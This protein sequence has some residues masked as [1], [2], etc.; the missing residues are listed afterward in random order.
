M[1]FFIVS[2]LLFT[3]YPTQAN[4]ISSAFKLI[5]Q[6]SNPLNQEFLKAVE[7]RDI[8]KAQKLLAEGA[9][10][11]ST[12]KEGYNAL[13][14]AFEKEDSKMAQILLKKNI[15][16]QAKNDKGD[17]AL[18]I[19]TQKGYENFIN[20]LVKKG[21]DINAKN[22]KGDTPFIIAF[23]SIIAVRNIKNKKYFRIPNFFLSKKPDIINSKGRQ[24]W[25]PLMVAVMANNIELVKWLLN[26]GADTKSK[27]KHGYTALR[28]SKTRGFI[29]VSKLLE[30]R[31]AKF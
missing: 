2:F 4:F 12:N 31:G 13:M 22:K 19:A 7:I 5:S 1:K 9:D 28:Y 8:K 15:N 30:E 29:N 6:N 14:I 20:L 17:T 11:N 23:N 16:I 25:T 26:H 27:D 10:I 24:G 3:A 18:H 21:A